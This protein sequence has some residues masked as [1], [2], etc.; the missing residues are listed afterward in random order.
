MEK[1]F[2]KLIS[3]LLVIIVLSMIFSFFLMV[4]CVK[5][6]D[7][8]R[9]QR[10]ILREKQRKDLPVEPER[11]PEIT[12]WDFNFRL[13]VTGQKDLY[14]WEVKGGMGRSI[15]SVKDRISPFV[16]EFMEDSE[17][18]M[19]RSPT[20]IF[21]KNKRVLTSTTDV[22]IDLPWAKIAGRGF[23][24]NMEDRFC[25]IL[26]DCHTTI[27][28]SEAGASPM[29]GNPGQVV[30][31]ESSDTAGKAKKPNILK[32]DSRKFYYYGSEGRQVW[33]EEVF[34]WDSNGVIK[35]DRM[36]AFNYSDE[37]K[38]KN[39]NLSGIKRIVCTGNVKIDQNTKW[40]VADTTVYMA[41]SDVLILTA[42]PGKKAT[43]WEESAD[44]ATATKVSANEIISYRKKN[45]FQ[46]TKGQQTTFDIPRSEINKVSI[47]GF[48]SKKK[49]KLFGPKPKRMDGKIGNAEGK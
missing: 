11:A 43:Y 21:D 17:P 1:N 47:L 4:F 23:R 38:A 39:P 24:F 15:D 35:A 27:E 18:V 48:D 9:V 33:A 34:A 28:K 30:A 16:G 7:K 25:K 42:K 10:L 22:L 26:N 2:K 5:A 37:E 46:A 12:R 19:L 14:R 41:E 20:V 3:G 6:A 36:E 31:D 45:S 8:E 44:K 32:I 13:P 29:M 40:A 49:L